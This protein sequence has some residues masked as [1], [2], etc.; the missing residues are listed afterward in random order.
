MEVWARGESFTWLCGHVHRNILSKFT[1]QAVGLFDEEF[2]H[3][4]ASSKPVMGLKSPGL[5]APLQ[6][7]AAPSPRPGRLSGSSHSTSDRASSNPFSSLSTGSNPQNRSLSTSSGPG[8]PLAPNP[9]L[10]PRFQPYHGP[11]G[12][13]TSQAHF[14]PRPHDGLSAPYSNLNGYRPLRL[15]VEQLGL[16]P[17]VAHTRRPFLQAFLNF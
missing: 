12:A 13:L 5:A 3:L 2:R 6:P 9:P 17:R 4:Y 8:S 11:W 1:G 16:V 7:T 15:Q 14:S 10:A